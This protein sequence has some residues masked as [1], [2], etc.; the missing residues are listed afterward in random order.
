M[1][2]EFMRDSNGR[3]AGQR[4]QVTRHQGLNW[5]RARIAKFVED[6]PGETPTKLAPYLCVKSDQTK[7][8]KA[9]V[10]RMIRIRMAK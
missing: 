1:I 5:I 3:K 7:D 9:R 4:Y 10:D 6:T 2:I 8:M